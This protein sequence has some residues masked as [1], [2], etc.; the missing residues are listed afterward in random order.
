[1]TVRYAVIQTGIVSEGVAI[2]IRELCEKQ[3]HSVSILWL[4]E[5]QIKKEEA[6]A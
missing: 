6:G 3:G 2:M 1:M 5:S 4:I